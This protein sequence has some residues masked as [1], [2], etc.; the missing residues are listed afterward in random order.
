M[1]FAEKSYYSSLLVANRGDAKGT[2][3]VLNTVINKKMCPNELPKH[4]E[5]NGEDI[6]DTSIIA[7]KCNTFFATIGP[8]LAN[9]LPAV[10][11]ASIGDYLGEHNINSMFLTPV[12]ESE[13]INIVK[14]CK[15]KNSKDCDD[16]SMYVISNVIVSIAKPLAHIFIYHSLVEFSQIT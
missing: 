2:W 1:R 3:N 15:P 9:A 14:L 11:D 5:C 6:S 8:N 13:I 7:N 4:F 10:E 12:D 16:I